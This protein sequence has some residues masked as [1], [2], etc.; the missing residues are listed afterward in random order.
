[1]KKTF[2]KIA[3]VV[4]L[5]TGVVLSAAWIAPSVTS[6]HPAAELN[7][8]SSGPLALPAP[9]IPGVPGLPGPLAKLAQPSSSMGLLNVSP[10]TG[11]VGTRMRIRGSNLPKRAKV[12]L[13][14]STADATWDVQ[15]SPGT[16]NYLGRQATKFPVVSVT[17]DTAGQEVDYF[18]FDRFQLDVRLDDDDFAAEKLWA[19]LP[20]EKPQTPTPKCQPSK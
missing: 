7:A 9:T 4:T 1:M 14:W 2:S 13:T 8:D 20:G 12:L 11:L 18:C 10:D 5:S 6:A 15:T 17:Y 19:P 16:V 3:L